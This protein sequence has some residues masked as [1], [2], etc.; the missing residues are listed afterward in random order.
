MT[1]Q[2]KEKTKQ[3]HFVR[4]YTLCNE[5]KLHKIVSNYVSLSV[6]I[7]LNNVIGHSA[8]CHRYYYYHYYYS[9]E[10]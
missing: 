4:V 3:T 9:D 8:H 1:I 10:A 7:F 2:W 6:I 5:W